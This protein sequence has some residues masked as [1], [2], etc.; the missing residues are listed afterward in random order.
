M[1]R[2][3]NAGELGDRRLRRLAAHQPLEPGPVQRPQDRAQAVGALRVAGR[4]VVR[5]ACGVRE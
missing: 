3:M 4:G 5:D 2:A 1:I